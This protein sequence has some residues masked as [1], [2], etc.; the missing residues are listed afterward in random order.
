MAATW[1]G[2]E[3]HKNADEIMP[4]AQHVKHYQLVHMMQDAL[5]MDDIK[6]HGDR[7]SLPMIF[8]ET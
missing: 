8:F 1:L 2:R 3:W 6:A 7:V 4:F 5:F